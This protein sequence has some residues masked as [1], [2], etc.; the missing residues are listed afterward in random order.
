MRHALLLLVYALLAML[1]LDLLWV[2]ISQDM[3]GR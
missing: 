3:T 2:A 1:A